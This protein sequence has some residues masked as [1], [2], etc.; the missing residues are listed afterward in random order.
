M[1]SMVGKLSN[2]YLATCLGELGLN[3]TPVVEVPSE[4][5]LL[6]LS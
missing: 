1:I 6:P 5:G 2:D 3:V 4:Q